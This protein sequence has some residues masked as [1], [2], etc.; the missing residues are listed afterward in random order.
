MRNVIEFLQELDMKEMIRQIIWI[1]SLFGLAIDM[2]P[3]IK[4]NPVRWC[5]NQ[6]GRMLNGARFDELKNDINQLQE[7]VKQNR[8]DQD[9]TRIKDIRSRIL[10]F[11]NSLAKRERDIEEFDEIF[12]LDDEYIDLLKRYEMKN[13]RTDRA[14][15]NIRKHYESMDEIKGMDG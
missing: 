7:E 4:V 3:W 12:D 15:K 8:F 9:K 5:F 6:L 2:T 10:D 1:C 11:S 14:M 13:G